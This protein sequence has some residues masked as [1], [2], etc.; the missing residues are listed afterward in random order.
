MNDYKVIF[1][2]PKNNTPQGVAIL[3]SAIAAHFGSELSTIEE[4]FAQ[5]PVPLEENL[6]EEAAQILIETFS[7]YADTVRFVNLTLKAPS[8]VCVE[9]VHSYFNKSPV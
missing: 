3:K 5:L 1:F 7:E 2:G 9:A 6:S 8:I 4:M